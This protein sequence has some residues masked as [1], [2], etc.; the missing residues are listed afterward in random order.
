MLSE[1]L[2]RYD[3]VEREFLCQGFEEGFRIPFSGSLVTSEIVKNHNSCNNNMDILYSKINH[4][5]R[6]GR[7][8]GPFDTPPIAGLTYSP[9]G[10]VPKHGSNSYR[11][12]HDLSFPRGQSVNSGITSENS[13]VFYDTIDTVIS[14]VKK[15]GYGALMAKT[16]IQDA[17]RLLPIHPN[18]YK[19]LGFSVQNNGQTEHYFDKCLPMGLSISCQTFERFSSAL[20]WYMEFYHH[21]SVSHV[22]D[23]FLFVGPM[24]SHSCK[25]QLEQ[26]LS[27]CTALH[28]PIKDEK[29]V[30]PTTKIVI[31][32]IEVD[33]ISM[34]FRLPEDKLQ[35]ING[36]LASFKHRK[37]VTLRELQS[38]LGLLNFAVSV[39]APGRAF[40]RRLYDLTI[41]ISRPYFKI[42]LNTA[43][44]ADLEAWHLF[45]RSFNGK[46]MFLN[47]KWISSD[48]LKLQTDA[49]TSTGY[50]A[51]F[52]KKWFYGAWSEELGGVSINVMELFPIVVAMELWGKCMAN[53]KILFLSDNTCTVNVVNNTTSKCPAMMR[54]VRRLVVACLSHNIM[55]KA[56][57]VPGAQNCLPD[58]ISRFHLQA[59]RQLAPWLDHHPTPVPQQYLRI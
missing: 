23:D 54:L 8:A 12:I 39:V 46:S 52:G 6:M 2:Q 47:D 44:R 36:L 5:I 59:A 9:L 24:A 4:E 58:A 10:L 53:H 56:K 29:T 45:M 14:L 34:T 21:A 1:L 57:H 40:L 32:G 15:H 25:R 48:T 16:D 55:F 43:A 22:I 26:F 13:K 17:F 11:L 51:V 27:L 50:A 3:P 35:K 20:Q 37:K 7:V 19:L 28:I 33:S 30:F 49:A 31:Y 41:G 18:D 38:L 42:R